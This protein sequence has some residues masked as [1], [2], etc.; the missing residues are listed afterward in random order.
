[1]SF[2]MHPL[3]WINDERMAEHC[4]ESGCIGLHIPDNQ[5]ISLGPREVPRASG[6]LLVV[7]DVQCT[8]YIVQP[9]TSLLSTVYGY[10]IFTIFIYKDFHLYLPGARTF[11]YSPAL[12]VT[13]F[14]LDNND[15]NNNYD[16]EMMMTLTTF[17]DN[18][19]NQNDRRNDDGM[20]IM[21]KATLKFPQLQHL[22][23]QP[24]PPPSPLDPSPAKHQIF[25]F[26]AGLNI[27]LTCFHF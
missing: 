20:T 26:A 1:M 17:K 23:Q 6:N 18:E 8:L 4:L 3:E 9:N 12:V 10:N 5:E 21:V 14:L 24:L 7:W 15:D 25:I 13:T 27:F 2:L 19:D 11:Q 22:L 16:D